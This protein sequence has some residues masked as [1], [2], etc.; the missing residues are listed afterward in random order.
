MRAQAIGAV[1]LPGSPVRLLAFGIRFAPPAILQR[2]LQPMVAGGRGDKPPSL[3]VDIRSGKTQSEIDALNG[4]I[5]QTGE[6][7][8]MKTPVNAAL[9]GILHDL[10]EGKVERAQW[11]RKRWP[12]HEHSKTQGRSKERQLFLGAIA[13]AEDREAIFRRGRPERD[14]VHEP[15]SL[16]R[17]G[18]AGNPFR[19]DQ[20]DPACIGQRPED[21]IHK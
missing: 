3:L 16:A 9:V 14:R 19:A 15:G 13:Q 17:D 12:G 6:A 10:L 21:R 20:F 18:G 4:A 1:N 11:R 8:G 2:I 7:N 5:V